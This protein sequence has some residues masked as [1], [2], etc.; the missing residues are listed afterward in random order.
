MV[1]FGSL[2]GV[3]VKVVCLC[4]YQSVGV[5]TKWARGSRRGT[6]ETNPTG[7]M[8]LLAK[9]LVSLSGLRIQC[10]HDLWCSSQM[11]LRSGVAV[12]LA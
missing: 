9:S 2:S 4:S 12:A 11:C 8:R 3:A 5:K 6:A 7:T 1:L 10:C